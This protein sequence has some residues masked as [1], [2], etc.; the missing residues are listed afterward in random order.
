MN[1]VGV[2]EHEDVF[3]PG[4]FQK[5]PR[6]RSESPLVIQHSRDLTIHAADDM[7]LRFLAFLGRRLH[8]APILVAVSVREEE[9]IDS[10][11]LR[12]TLDELA[13]ED[14]LVCLTLAGL[15]R[16][17]TLALVRRIGRVDSHA[18]SMAQRGE[19]VWEASAGNP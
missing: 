11:L 9:L 4:P 3:C 19:Q 16:E 10:Q 5:I 18:A 7:S 14:R 15:G 8:E 13:G 12:S 2:H 1:R 17:D 6:W